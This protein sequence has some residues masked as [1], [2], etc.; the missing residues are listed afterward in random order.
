MREDGN[1]PRIRSA[2]SNMITLALE[3]AVTA[4]QYFYPYT[5]W[6]EGLPV[7]VTPISGKILYMTG[8]LTRHR[9][10]ELADL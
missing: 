6:T 9:C 8:K 5:G 10:R 1:T 2:D 4:G 7:A 3:L